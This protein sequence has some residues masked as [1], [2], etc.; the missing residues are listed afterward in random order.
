MKAHYYD[1]ENGEKVRTEEIPAELLEQAKSMRQ[2]P[3]RGG[4]RLRRQ[5]HRAVPRGQGTRV[6][7]I[8]RA[9]RAGTSSSS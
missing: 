6:E 7:D 9:V 1:G 3:D 8:R 4:R 2:R 5:A